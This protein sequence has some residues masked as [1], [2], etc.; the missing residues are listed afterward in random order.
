MNMQ[1]VGIFIVMP[2]TLYSK[3]CTGVDPAAPAWAFGEP[4]KSTA[5]T[6]ARAVAMRAANLMDKVYSS[7]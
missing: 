6:V 2:P 1:P 5:A 3:V 7:C 4:D